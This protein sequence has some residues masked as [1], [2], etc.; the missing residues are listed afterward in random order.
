MDVRFLE[1]F[2]EVSDCGSVAEAAR[3]LNLTPAAVMLRLKTIERELGHPLVARAGRTSRLTASGLAV[4]PKARALIIEARNLRALAADKEPAGELRLGSIAT[5]LTGI[6]PPAIAQLSKRH[7]G[8]DFFIKPGSSSDLYDRVSRGEIDAALIVQP[9]FPLPKSISWQTLRE[10]PL[11]L[12]VPRAMKVTTVGDALATARFIRYDRNQWGGQIV[13]R[14][15][16]KNKLKVREWLELDALDSIAVFV[17]RGLGVA[18][19]PDWVGFWPEGLRLKKIPLADCEMRRLGL[20]W[21]PASPRISAI[22]ALIDSC[23][24]LPKSGS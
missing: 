20:L 19:V 22:R 24:G 17:S 6:L 21:N 15:L 23:V 2:V 12:L 1:S 13:D 5:G 10:E 18:I 4:L 7:P 14:Y 8:I 3:R 9:P 16:R 11:V